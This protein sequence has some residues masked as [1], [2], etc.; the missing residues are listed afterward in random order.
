MADP[1]SIEHVEEHVLMV[2][3][4]VS[5]CLSYLCCE[6]ACRKDMCVVFVVR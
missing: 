3:M 2:L 1:L 5:N 4:A 6:I